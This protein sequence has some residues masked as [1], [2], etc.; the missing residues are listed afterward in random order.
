MIDPWA[1]PPKRP[2]NRQPLV[3]ICGR[4]RSGKDTLASIFVES[5]GFRRVSFA[6][7]VKQLLAAVNPLVC[8]NPMAPRDSFNRLAAYT[9]DWE[10]AKEIPEVRRLLQQLG[11]TARDLLGESVW[12]NPV[13]G[14]VQSRLANHE[15]VVISDVRFPNEADRVRSLGGVIVRVHRDPIGSDLISTHVSETAMDAYHADVDINNVGSLDSLRLA[16][17][18]VLDRVL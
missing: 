14:E 9:D 8:L 4:K 3:G 12:I 5:Y 1:L 18:D 15:Q 6:A 2:A 11:T 13:I 7:R 16:A 10:D 17:A